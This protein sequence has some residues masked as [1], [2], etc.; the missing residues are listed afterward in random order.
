MSRRVGSGTGGGTATGR[1]QAIRLSGR[2]H[3]H[4]RASELECSACRRPVTGVAVIV[5]GSV[6]CTWDCATSVAG[7]VPGLYF[8]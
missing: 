1:H 4:P 7:T 8:G 5:A 6:Y 2:S 3:L